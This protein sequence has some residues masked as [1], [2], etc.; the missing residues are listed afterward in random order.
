MTSTS[1]T[2][3]RKSASKARKDQQDR[4]RR[5]KEIF[6]AN[7]CF[8]CHR[9]A[10]KGSDDGVALDGIAQRRAKSFLQEHLKDPEEHVAH[11]FKEFGG[12]PNLMTSPNLSKS[13]IDAVV[14]YLLSLPAD[15]ALKL[16]KKH[17]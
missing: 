17:K 12:D 7:G 11:N 14:A 4:I 15:P 13:E 3:A 16:H 8:D 2:L 10:G 5:G 9:V 6:L 1:K